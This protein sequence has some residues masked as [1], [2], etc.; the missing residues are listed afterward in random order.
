MK[1]VLDWHQQAH[2]TC[3][4]PHTPKIAEICSPPVK[5]TRLCGDE[6]TCRCFYET[7]M[8]GRIITKFN[9]SYHEIDRAF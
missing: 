4:K 7:G 3:G 9:S 1:D 6:R 8:S 5:G 2:K